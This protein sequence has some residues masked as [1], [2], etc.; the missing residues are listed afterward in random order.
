MPLSKEWF[1][2]SDNKFLHTVHRT[3][4]LGKDGYSQQVGD[5][6]A[7]V[8]EHAAWVFHSLMDDI[9]VSLNYRDT[10]I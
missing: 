6:K 3:A 7:T 2:H 9:C 10:V 1:I 8:A 5:R 4:K